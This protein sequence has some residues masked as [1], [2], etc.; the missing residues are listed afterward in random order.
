MEAHAE[1]ALCQAG[2]C[3]VLYELLPLVGKPLLMSLGAQAI[4][5]AAVDVQ[6]RCRTSMPAV[7]QRLVGT[8][9]RAPR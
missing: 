3:A 5:K 7:V 8:F 4:V 1:N 6:R 9:R 2:G